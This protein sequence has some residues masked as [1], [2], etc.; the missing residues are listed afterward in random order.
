MWSRSAA[1]L[2]YTEAAQLSSVQRLD[3]E[4]VNL[5]YCVT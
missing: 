5:L 4:V 3:G 2:A 1:L